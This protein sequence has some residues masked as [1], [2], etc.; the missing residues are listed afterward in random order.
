ME[1]YRV[2]AVHPNN[3]IYA[4]HTQHS[5]DTLLHAKWDLWFVYPSTDAMYYEI[6]VRLDR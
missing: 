5:R 3:V 1:M 6:M 4:S 2:H